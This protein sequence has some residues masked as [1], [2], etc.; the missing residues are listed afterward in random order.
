MLRFTTS[1]QRPLN[2]DLGSKMSLAF[3]G[4]KK[5]G[6]VQG[7]KG[8]KLPFHAI[9]IFNTVPPPF[10]SGFCLFLLFPSQTLT[11]CTNVFPSCPFIP[12]SAILRMLLL[13]FFLSTSR[14]PF[15]LFTTGFRCLMCPKRVIIYVV[16]PDEAGAQLAS[17]ASVQR[18]WIREARFGGGGGEKGKSPPTI[19][20]CARLPV[21][22][23]QSG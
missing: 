5:G 22:V 2:S 8:S 21:N 7:G 16:L 1:H 6:E 13:I 17:L 14:R 10:F 19:S 12:F 11:Q 20:P 23:G 15:V 3:N 18:K 4:S 9:T